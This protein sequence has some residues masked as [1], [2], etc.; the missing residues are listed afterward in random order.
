MGLILIR[1][2]FSATFSGPVV[3]ATL[4]HVKKFTIPCAFGARMAP[5]NVYV[6]E[7]AREPAGTHPLEQQAAWLERER[8]GV[9]PAKVMTG[10]AQLL[11]MARES[12]V[13][14]EE[15]CA[16]A[17]GTHSEPSAAVDGD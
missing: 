3:R 10:F 14:Y 9:I 8:G 17:L 1:G 12:D 16:Y 15:L 7:P 13:G 6:G 2:R 4:S 11:E 5:F